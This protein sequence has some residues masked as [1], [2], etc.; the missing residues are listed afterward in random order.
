MI[1]VFPRKILPLP[2]MEGKNPKFT[3]EE[4]HMKKAISTLDMQSSD[5]LRKAYNRD[6]TNTFIKTLHKKAVSNPP[7][8]I[9]IEIKGETR[10]GKSSAGITI[11]KLI[12]YYHGLE[13]TEEN[14]LPNQGELLYRLKDA[15]Y[16]ETFLVD[17]QTPE[18]FGEGVLRESAQLGSNLNICAK[19]CNNLIFIYPPHFTMRNSPYGLETLAKDYENKYIKLWYHDLATKSFGFGG[20][21]PRGFINLPKFRDET[22]MKKNKKYWSEERTHHFEEA[23]YDYDS[24]LE[25]RYELRKDVWI[26]EIRNMDSSVRDKKKLEVA[27]NLAE[28]DRFINLSNVGKKQAYIKLRIANGDIIDLT[29][30]EIETLTNMATVIFEIGDLE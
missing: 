4:N 27:Q 23:H 6:L 21:W 28:D 24:E 16:G 14:I 5:A 12:S 8:N 9:N 18:A 2:K 15:K 26:E 1:D 3:W 29:K 13:F 11:G 20:V 19:K 17:E 22:Y 10:S 7:E 25:E 30:G